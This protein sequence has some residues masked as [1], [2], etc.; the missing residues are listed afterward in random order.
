MRIA[1][2][3]AQT[4]DGNCKKIEGSSPRSAQRQGGISHAHAQLSRPPRSNKSK[5]ESKS[6]FISRSGTIRT[7]LPSPPSRGYIHSEVCI[8]CVLN[9]MCGVWI[10]TWLSGLVLGRVDV[11]FGYLADIEDQRRSQGA[12]G[13]STSIAVDCLLVI[14]GQWVVYT[15]M[16]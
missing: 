11:Y 4:P 5:S 14:V 3:L 6:K 16:A 9:S 15:T 8:L 2:H 7:S 1:T 13:S 12:P 10:R